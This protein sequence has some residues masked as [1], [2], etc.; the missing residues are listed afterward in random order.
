MSS[1]TLKDEITAAREAFY[2]VSCRLLHIHAG[3]TVNPHDPEP[4]AIEGAA[5]LLLDTIRMLDGA[6]SQLWE[7]S[8]LADYLN[9]AGEDAPATQ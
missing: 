1:T 9:S 8:S 7:E 3:L 5:S 4:L 2:T 6:A